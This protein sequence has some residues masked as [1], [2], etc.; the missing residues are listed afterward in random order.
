M[1]GVQFELPQRE[2]SA[3][4]AAIGFEGSPGGEI[5]LV[6][7]QLH[8]V[9]KVPRVCVSTNLSLQRRVQVVRGAQERSQRWV[10]SVEKFG[11]A[12]LVSNTLTNLLV[13]QGQHPGEL[14]VV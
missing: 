10:C 7:A 13:T 1:S 9:L 3:S 6:V 14:P 12:K 8:V 5:Q 2:R 11:V 4:I